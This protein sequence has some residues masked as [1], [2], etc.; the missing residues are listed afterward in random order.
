VAIDLGVAV[1]PGRTWFCA[2]P[3]GSYVRVSVAAADGAA[4]AEGVRR[5][6]V[7]VAAA[8]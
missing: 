6:G 3:T 2:E 4:I 5:L 1:T 8:G 7:A